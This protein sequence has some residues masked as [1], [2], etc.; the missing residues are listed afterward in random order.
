MA[1]RTVLPIEAGQYQPYVAVSQYS[2][3][4]FASTVTILLHKTADSVEKRRNND[5]QSEQITIR[6]SWDAYEAYGWQQFSRIVRHDLIH[7]WQ[8]HEY[9]KADHGPTFHQWVEPLETDR[10]REQYAEPNYWVIYEECESCD[11]RYRRS[12]VVKLSE[13][14]LCGQCGGEISVENA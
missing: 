13:K 12:K 7:V 14:Y 2:S 4:T 1:I 9:D 5:H 6:L 8:Y 11:S 10:H 3:N